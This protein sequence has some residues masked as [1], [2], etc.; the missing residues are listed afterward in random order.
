LSNVGSFINLVS[1]FIAPLVNDT[2]D[3]VRVSIFQI[4]QT[5]GQLDANSSLTGKLYTIFAHQ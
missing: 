2:G 5:N 1:S 4:Y 3:C